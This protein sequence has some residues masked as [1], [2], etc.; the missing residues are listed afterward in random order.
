MPGAEEPVPALCSL[1]EGARGQNGEAPLHHRISNSVPPAFVCAGS[2][3]ALPAGGMEWDGMAWNSMGWNGMLSPPRVALPRE[4]H[5]CQRPLSPAERSRAVRGRGAPGASG[6]IAIAGSGRGEAAF[7]K[8]AR[9]K[10]VGKAHRGGA[11]ML[12][13]KETRGEVFLRTSSVRG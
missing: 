13:E 10:S 3:A 2:L 6:R 1:P 5:L 8:P 11:G 7:P 9:P 4:G 12:R